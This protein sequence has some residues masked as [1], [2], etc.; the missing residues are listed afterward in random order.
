RRCR[1]Y[2][3]PEWRCDHRGE[4]PASFHAQAALGPPRHRRQCLEQRRQ[5]GFH[6]SSRSA[7]EP[8]PAQ[9][10]AGDVRKTDVTKISFYVLPDETEGRNPRLHLACR[11]TEKAMKTGIEGSKLTYVLCADEGMLSE[12]DDLLWTFSQGSFV[13]H[14]RLM[15]INDLKSTAPVI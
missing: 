4:L 9:P 12:F 11:I 10:R 14:E 15:D 8:V 1:Q 7:A 2:R 6:R 3:W 5:Q 13:A